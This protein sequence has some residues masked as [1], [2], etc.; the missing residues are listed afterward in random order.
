MDFSPEKNDEHEFSYPT[1]VEASL[2]CILYTVQPPQTA[3]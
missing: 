1:E 3:T 2:R